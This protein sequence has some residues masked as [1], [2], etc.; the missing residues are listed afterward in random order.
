[1]RLPFTYL[2]KLAVGGIWGAVGGRG[3]LGRGEGQHAT[4]YYHMHTSRGCVCLGALGYRG[5]YAIIPIS[6]LCH[7]ES[8][9]GLKNQRHNTPFN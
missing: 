6:H 3:W 8:L 9:K 1:M 2:P 7:E 4:D 5:T